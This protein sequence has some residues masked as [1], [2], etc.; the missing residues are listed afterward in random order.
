M[1]AFID[2]LYNP[3]VLTEVTI[4]SLASSYIVTTRSFQIR[5]AAKS[6]SIPI[7]GDDRYGGGSLDIHDS[8]ADWNRT[9]LHAT[10]IHLELDDDEHVTIWSPPPFDHLFA[11][12]E[13]ID[14][15]VKL[16]KKHCDCSP[17]LDIIAQSDKGNTS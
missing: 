13:L 10:A 4:I 5:V 12:G 17:I 3:H 1:S 9:F 2:C 14:V 7:L 11:K 16:T 15:F 6:S 8:Y